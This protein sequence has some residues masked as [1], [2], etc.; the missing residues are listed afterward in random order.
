MAGM[1][2]PEAQFYHIKKR[3]VKEREPGRQIGHWP[4]RQV[5]PQCG[6]HQSCFLCG[7]LLAKG[8]NAMKRLPKSWALLVSLTCAIS[9]YLGVSLVVEASVAAGPLP[10]KVSESVAGFSED[11]EGIWQYQSEF[12]DC[13]TNFLFFRR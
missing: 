4:L 12:R 7:W 1:L 5:A 2:I 10:L 9:I 8:G 11:W 6:E 3:Y 13:E